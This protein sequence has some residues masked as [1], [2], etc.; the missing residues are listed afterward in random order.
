MKSTL[1]KKDDINATIVIELEKADYQEQVDK[2]LNQL[3]HRAD[4]P[5]FRKGKV[6]KGI[7]QKMYGKS[8]LVDEINKIV[9]EEVANYI[10]D[11]NVKVLGEPL[12]D[13]SEDKMV[14]LDKDENYVFHFDVGLTPEFEMP[15]DKS[16]ELTNYIVELEDDLLNKQIDAYKQNFGN[17]L[18]VEEESVDTDLIKGVLTELENGN[19]KEGG[20]VIENAIIMPSYIKDEEIKKS[21][22]GAKVGDKVAFDPKKAYENNMAEV[23]SLLQT[24]KEDAEKID[25]EFSFEINEVTRFQE[26][27]INQELFDKVLGEGAVTTE[28]EFRNKV[29]ENLEAQFRPNADHLINHEARDII[30][31]RMKDVKFPDEFLKRW[32]KETNEGRS[33]EDIEKDYPLL[34]EDL[35]YHVVRQRIIEDNELKVESEEIDELAKDVA[36]AQFAQYGMSNL[37]DDMLQNY[38]KSLL[39]N[40]E[41]VRNLFDRVLDNKVLDWLKENVTVIEK[42]VSTEEFNKIVTE[43]SHKHDEDADGEHVHDE[44]DEHNEEAAETETKD[45]DK[46]VKKAEKEENK[47]AK[48][49]SKKEAKEEKKDEDESQKA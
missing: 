11:N 32:L 2:S 23:A 13:N 9:S 35:R 30:V 8:V 40:Q 12:P 26:A 1:N 47:K 6:P 19:V 33:D 28:E 29:K 42:K 31:E 37:P 49:E 44:T 5:G 41:T 18:K 10:R 21:F 22:I 7:I 38:A 45:L 46:E 15:V 17:Y 36:R 24:T 48:K 39:E 43:H 34:L 3:R 16:I 20:K 4:I 14:D 27:E 25:S